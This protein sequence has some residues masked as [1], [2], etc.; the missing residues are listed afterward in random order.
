MIFRKLL[1][2]LPKLQSDCLAQIFIEA[3][4]EN[5]PADKYNLRPG[6][7]ILEFSSKK[8]NEISI[9]EIRNQLNDDNVKNINLLIINTDNKKREV[10]LEK[11]ILFPESSNWKGLL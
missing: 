11:K 5:T 7:E 4:L 9:N 1:A 10:I 8:S 3:I 2:A 6:D